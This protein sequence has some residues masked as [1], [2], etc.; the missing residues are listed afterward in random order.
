MRDDEIIVITGLV[1]AICGAMKIANKAGTIIG[2]TDFRNEAEAEVEAEGEWVQPRVQKHGENST[3]NWVLTS[4]LVL[5]YHSTVHFPPSNNLRSGRENLEKRTDSNNRGLRFSGLAF[6]L[7]FHRTAGCCQWKGFIQF[8]Y[9]NHSVRVM[10]QSVSQSTVRL[11]ESM[12]SKCASRRFAHFTYTVSGA[13]YKR[14]FV[15]MR[16]MS[17]ANDSSSR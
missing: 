6:S 11:E 8:N 15:K 12:W 4:N 9:I 2:P 3:G 10:S 13:L 17:S 5:L 14:A 7:S 1:I 16:R